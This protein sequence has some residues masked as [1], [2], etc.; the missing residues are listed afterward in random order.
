MYIINVNHDSCNQINLSI[1]KKRPFEQ[2]NNYYSLFFLVV[3]RLN[4]LAENTLFGKAFRYYAT[5][6]S[7]VL[8]FMCNV[9]QS[10]LMEYLQ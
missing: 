4:K 7:I 1:K 5:F 6:K 3:P 8:H 9:Q 2:R 10:K